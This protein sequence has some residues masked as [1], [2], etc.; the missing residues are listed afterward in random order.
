M[1]YNKSKYVKYKIKYIQTKYK[2]LLYDAICMYYGLYDINY[3][4]HNDY[5]N[6]LNE[7]SFETT[8]N[9]LNNN[10]LANKCFNDCIKLLQTN[11]LYCKKLNYDKCIPNC[12]KIDDIC[13]KT[14]LTIEP[15]KINSYTDK[16]INSRYNGLTNYI[17]KIIPINLN[18]TK[19]FITVIKNDYNKIIM[20]PS[21]YRYSK[22]EFEQYINFNELYGAIFTPLDIDVNYILCGHSMGAVLLQILTTCSNFV[23]NKNLITRCTIVGSGAYLWCSDITIINKFI[24]NF[25]LRYIFFA[26]GLFIDDV[27]QNVIDDYL[28]SKGENNQNDNIKYYSFPMYIISNSA[29]I[30]NNVLKIYTE[31]HFFDLQLIICY[32]NKYKIYGYKNIFIPLDLLNNNLFFDINSKDK[33]I[34]SNVDNYNLIDLHSWNIYSKSILFL[35]NL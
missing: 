17:E 10:N 18:N 30:K 8:I 21:G 32:R 20:F 1:N 9:Y 16:K 2:S 25:N 33:S 35:L 15:N 3:K 12:E 26:N 34:I 19:Y 14:I 31:K 7:L 28:F 6:K 24:E 22:S 29:S 13:N 23:N 5:K 27:K 11:N 4:I